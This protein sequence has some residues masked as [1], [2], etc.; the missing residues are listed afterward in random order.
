MET[1]F[2]FINLR[3]ASNVLEIHLNLRFKKKTAFLNNDLVEHDLFQPSVV[4]PFLRRQKKNT[5]KVTLVTT[6]EDNLHLGAEYGR[7]SQLGT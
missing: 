2:K 3:Y 5:M 4:Q 1:G 7:S 6:G